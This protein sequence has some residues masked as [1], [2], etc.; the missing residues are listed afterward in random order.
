MQQRRRW[1]GIES[2]PPCRGRCG[3]GC[4]CGLW[5][6]G[7]AGMTNCKMHGLGKV[8]WLNC[9]RTARMAW[10]AKRGEME[11]I[12]SSGSEDDD[13]SD[14]CPPSASFESRAL[15]QLVVFLSRGSHYTTL[16][17][18]FLLIWHLHAPSPGDR[19]CTNQLERIVRPLEGA[20]GTLCPNR[21]GPREPYASSKTVPR[22]HLQ[23]VT[24]C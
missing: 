8:L 20:I 22:H 7:R 1:V 2:S 4:G 9:C 19:R 3:C 5:V 23:S 13:R 10:M 16:R 14:P 17:R 24:C 18:Q 12:G 6:V 21:G 11:E 15:A